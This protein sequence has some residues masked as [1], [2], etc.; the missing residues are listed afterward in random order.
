VLKGNRRFGRTYHFHRQDFNL[1]FYGAGV[2]P[3][4]LSLRPFICQFYQPWMINSGDRG[5]VSGMS[6]RGNRSTRRKP[7][8]VPLCPQIPHD[9][10]WARTW[11]AAVV[12]RRTN[13]LSHGTAYLGRRM[14]QVK[15]FIPLTDAETRRPVGFYYVEDPTFSRSLQ[16]N[17]LFV[18]PPR[19]NFL[20]LCTP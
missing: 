2:E 18:P 1:F 11:A 8:P 20:R 10:T 16:F 15:L 19:F 4:P 7:A 6:S 13:R 12:S 5:A 17:F 9:L 3:S 14:T